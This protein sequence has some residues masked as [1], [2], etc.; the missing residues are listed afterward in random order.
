MH[1]AGPAPCVH[2]RIAAPGYHACMTQVALLVV[3][4]LGAI[5]VLL[6]LVA[7]HANIRTWLQLPGLAFR[8]EIVRTRPR[9]RRRRSGRRS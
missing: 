7:P 5:V 9:A 6:A 2:R 4:A 1:T 8:T 3:G